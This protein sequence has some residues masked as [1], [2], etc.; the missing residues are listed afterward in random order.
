MQFVACFGHDGYCYY[1]VEHVAAVVVAGVACFENFVVSYWP[2]L[3][4]K[5]FCLLYK[6]LTYI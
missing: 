5:V 2:N 6:C 4:K 3:K 1:D